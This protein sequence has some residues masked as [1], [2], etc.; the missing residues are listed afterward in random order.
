MTRKELRNYASLHDMPIIE[1]PFMG[2]QNMQRFADFI[3]S[4]DGTYGWNWDAFDFGGFF[5]VCTGY[6]NTI[7]DDK[8]ADVLTRFD[9]SFKVVAGK[10]TDERE[11]E[12]LF[13]QACAII[14]DKY[15][16]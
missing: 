13:E 16:S 11:I 2:V 14:Y 1:V 6:R 7:G 5:I 9:N 8:H 3:G 10:L 4:N 15:M 12:Q